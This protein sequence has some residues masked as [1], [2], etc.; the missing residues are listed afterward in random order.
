MGGMWFGVA[1]KTNSQNT[2][3]KHSI[4]GQPI[5]LVLWNALER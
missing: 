2:R 5:F 1:S 4:Q 3:I